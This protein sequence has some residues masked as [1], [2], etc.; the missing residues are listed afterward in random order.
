MG[1]LGDLFERLLARVFVLASRDVVVRDLVH[2]IACETALST[3]PDA[4]ETPEAEPGDPHTV[5][6]DR[7]DATPAPEGNAS[8]ASEGN[9]TPGAGTPLSTAPGEGEGGFTSRSLESEPPGKSPGGEIDR[10]PTPEDMQEWLETDLADIERNCRLKARAAR[11]A[12]ERQ[13]RIAGGA[14]YRVDIE[15]VDRGLIDEARALP[16]CYLWMSSPDFPV[17]GDLG[18]LDDLA[19]AFETVADAVLMARN[20][21]EAADFAVF[22]NTLNL[23][24]EAQASLRAS[25]GL[26]SSRR[27]QDQFRTYQW[28]RAISFTRHIYLPRYMKY[29][30]VPDPAASRS[31]RERIERIRAEETSKR[32]RSREIEAA[33]NRVRYH[34]KAILRGDGSE[35]SHD[36]TKVT[37]AVDRMIELGVPPSAVSLRDLLLPIIDQLPEGIEISPRFR[38]FLRETDRYLASRPASTEARG[39]RPDL[40]REIAPQ[41]QAVKQLLEGTALTLIGGERREDASEALVRVFGLLRVDWLT[42]REHSSV[43]DFESYIARA[44]V[45]VVLLAI[46][47]SSHS[48]GDVRQFCDRYEKFLVRLPAGYNPTQVASQILE[49]CGERLGLM[50]R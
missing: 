30:D 31:L 13:S 17:P 4:A 15:P 43:T 46:R 29:D 22:E 48:F 39:D 35:C 2:E 23:V 16:G 7:P 21:Q 40:P 3:E 37:Q 47:W 50:R 25:I 49:Q 19:L 36:W 20:L 5:A 1:H 32:N 42:S 28:L 38:L 8:R 10:R 27:D 14:D 9:S 33:E 11:W 26:L 24:T 45:R 6:E 41:V 44:D 18:L 12:A 34:L